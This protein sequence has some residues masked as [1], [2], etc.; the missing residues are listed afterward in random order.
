MPPNTDRYPE[1]D[2]SASGQEEVFTV[3]DGAVTL[4]AGD[5]E[6]RLEPGAFARIGPN[7][8][9]KLLTGDEGATVLALGGVPGAPFEPVTYTNE[10]EP[11]PLDG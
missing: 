4:L 3:L 2:H 11:D 8:N 6:Y 10:G 5:E 9:R 1:H 7:E